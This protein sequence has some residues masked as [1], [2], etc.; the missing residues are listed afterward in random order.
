M[1]RISRSRSGRLHGVG[2]DDAPAALQEMEREALAV[3]TV[4]ALT[5][6]HLDGLTRVHN[7]GFGSKI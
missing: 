2:D 4:H 3:T 5:M 7:E 6:E 1:S